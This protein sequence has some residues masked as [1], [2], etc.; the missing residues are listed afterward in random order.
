[1]THSDELNI[2]RAVFQVCGRL[3]TCRRG[4]PQRE[5]TE[6]CYCP[7]TMSSS[8]LN[9]MTAQDAAVSHTAQSHVGLFSISCYVV[10]G[11]D[12]TLNISI[13]LSIMEK[14]IYFTQTEIFQ[15]FI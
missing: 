13:N 3:A 9:L 7:W 14:F 2:V 10:R 5:T 15:V 4:P 6:S 12:L 8:A 11:S 1:M